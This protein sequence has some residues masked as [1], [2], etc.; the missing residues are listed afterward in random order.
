MSEF[1]RNGVPAGKRQATSALSS[2]AP[3]TVIPG[4]EPGTNPSTGAANDPRHKVGDDGVAIA[5][6]RTTADILRRPA[7][8]PPHYPAQAA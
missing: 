7:E 5:G 8:P 1:R 2:T 3:L 6:G 4:L